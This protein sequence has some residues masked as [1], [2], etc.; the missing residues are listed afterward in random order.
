MSESTYKNPKNE[1]L[2]QNHPF[3]DVRN[4]INFSRNTGDI[5]D[6]TKT[7]VTV[8]FHVPIFYIK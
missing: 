3:I 8:F 7:R 4:C 2:M 5:P 1:I 6:C